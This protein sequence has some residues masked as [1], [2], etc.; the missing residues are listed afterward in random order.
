MKGIRTAALIGALVAA[1]GVAQASEMGDTTQSRVLPVLVQVDTLG[2]VTSASPATPLSPAM[3]RLLRQSL[4]QMINQPAMVHGTPVPSQF[5]INLALDAT[6]R[7]DGGYQATFRYVSTS[8]VPT[9]SWYWVSVDNGRRFALGDRH[10]IR[11]RRVFD[12]PRRYVPQ[13]DNRLNQGSPTPPKTQVA[14]YRPAQAQRTQPPRG[15]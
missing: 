12:P 1:A 5:V 2:Q 8:P 15:R 14:S 4:D 3:D 7:A 10:D 13:Q 6:T 11:Q 9:G